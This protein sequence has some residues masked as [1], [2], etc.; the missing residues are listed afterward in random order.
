MIRSIER[1]LEKEHEEWGWQCIESPTNQKTMN[2]AQLMI[3]LHNDHNNDCNWITM[4]S[5]VEATMSSRINTQRM[6]NAYTTKKEYE[7]DYW[8]LDH[9]ILNEDQGADQYLDSVWLEECLWTT[10]NT[11]YDQKRICEHRHMTQGMTSTWTITEEL[12]YTRERGSRTSI[13][14][15]I[16]WFRTLLECNKKIVSRITTP[17]D[18]RQ[19]RHD[20]KVTASEHCSLLED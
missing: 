2:S 11:K 20:I 19:L 14:A 8:Q 18:I 5:M 3:L 16:L 15:D 1:R 10:M 9:A 17:T 4:T 12:Q 6:N 13:A 7:V